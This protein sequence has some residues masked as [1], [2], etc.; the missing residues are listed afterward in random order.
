[1]KA[2]T[3]VGFTLGI[4]LAYFIATKLK[5]DMKEKGKQVLKDKICELLD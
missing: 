4:T 1:M 5:S 2:G 3:I